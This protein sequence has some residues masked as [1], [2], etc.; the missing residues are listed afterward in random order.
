MGCGPD[1]PGASP[2]G[3][4]R[5]RGG[6]AGYRRRARV[7]PAAG[8]LAASIGL[9]VLLGLGDS[10]VVRWT[11]D[12]DPRVYTSQG[13]AGPLVEAAVDRLRADAAQLGRGPRPDLAPGRRRAR[14]RIT[15]R[16]GW[17]LLGSSTLLLYALGV[18]R[19]ARLRLP[20]WL[21]VLAAVAATVLTIVWLLARLLD[22]VEP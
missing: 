19:V 15:R 7:W 5:R 22:A 1:R 13:G 9:A 16:I 20:P 18:Y 2:R 11:I 17:T 3:R 12:D 10:G 4:A 14:L 21:A 8:T 6:V